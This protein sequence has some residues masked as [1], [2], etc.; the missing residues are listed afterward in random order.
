VFR[1]SD[2]PVGLVSEVANLREGL[3]TN[4]HRRQTGALRVPQSGLKSIKDRGRQIGATQ[5][6]AQRIIV[7]NEGVVARQWDG[8][9]KGKRDAVIRQV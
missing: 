6:P 5:Q 1:A 9:P 4:L 3:L 8:R 2:R 7:G